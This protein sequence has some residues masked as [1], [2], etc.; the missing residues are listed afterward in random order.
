M[1]KQILIGK[2]WNFLINS[3]ATTSKDLLYLPILMVDLKGIYPYYPVPSLRRASR[4]SAVKQSLLTGR[5]MKSSRYRIV[6]IN[7]GL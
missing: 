6:K 3:R 1:V 7:F 2:G 5:Y 4:Y